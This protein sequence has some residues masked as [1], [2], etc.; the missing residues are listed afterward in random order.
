NRTAPARLVFDGKQGQAIVASLIDMGGR[1]RLIVNDI[2][3]V[4]PYEMPNLPVARVMW[5]ALPS[6]QV[7]AEAWIVSGAAHHS[8]LS[9]D[10]NADHM[11]DWAEIMD[12]E[13]VHINKET[14][15]NELK[16]DLFLSDLAWKLK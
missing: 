2:E 16:R 9:F 5:K 7:S 15:I 4:K 11:R 10:L 13:F 12:I 14:T 3:A 1:L 6:L 8:V